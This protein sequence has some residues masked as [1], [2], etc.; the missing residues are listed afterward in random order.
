MKPKL[1]KTGFGWIE[2]D[3]LR[4]EHDILIRPDGEII[5]RKKKLSKQ[6]YGT[7]HTISLEEAEYI[8]QK[9]ANKI[10]IGTGQTGLL[11]LSSAAKSYFENNN[12]QVE[13]APTPEA[14]KIWN[15]K[16]GDV[17]GLFHLTC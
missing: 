17:I 6:V 14:I 7:S 13:L 2:I 11:K 15:K 16:S 4:Y 1:I 3:G 9:R 12:C 5:K 8:F 10:I